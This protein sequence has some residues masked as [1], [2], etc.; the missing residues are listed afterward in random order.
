M[1]HGVNR[2][3]VTLRMIVSNWPRPQC[4]ADPSAHSFSTKGLESLAGNLSSELP[5]LFL[6]GSPPLDG[7]RIQVPD[8]P[9]DCMQ[10][11]QIADQ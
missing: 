7:Q 4:P 3:K 9:A 2:P 10:A 5:R 11:Y 6:H 8:C 1:Q